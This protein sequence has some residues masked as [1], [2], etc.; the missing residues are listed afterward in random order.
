MKKLVCSL[1]CSLFLSA[2]LMAQDFDSAVGLRL[3]YPS[4]VTYKKFISETNALEA[5]GGFRSYAFVNTMSV[6]AAYQI[7]KDIE[8]IDNLQWYYGGGGGLFF[9]S[10]DFDGSQTSIGIQ[11]YIGLSYTLED[12]PV[13]FTVDWVPTMILGDGL[14]SFSNGFSAS[15]YSLG[16]R[17]VLGRDSSS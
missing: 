14:S 17:Y 5:Y 12:T 10:S 4:G 9:V 15:Y 1:I 2:G 8:D 13:N 16:I 3:G 6:H 11:G 7:H